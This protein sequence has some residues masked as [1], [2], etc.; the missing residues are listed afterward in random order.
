MKKVK[1]KKRYFDTFKWT[2]KE[3]ETIFFLFGANL[4]SKIV[5]SVH[6]KKMIKWYVSGPNIKKNIFFQPSSPLP[7]DTSWHK[8]HE[9]RRRD[10]KSHTWAPLSAHYMVPSWFVL[11][12]HGLLGPYKVP[13]QFWYA[14]FL[15]GPYLVQTTVCDLYTCQ[16]YLLGHC[17]LGLA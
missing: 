9:N 17:R 8:N 12:L 10:W 15:P 16:S 1:N 13:T 3:S 5:A 4:K 7:I 14:W 6:W 2:S 11:S